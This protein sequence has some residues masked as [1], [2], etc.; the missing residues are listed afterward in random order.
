MVAGSSGY[1]TMVISTASHVPG[2]AIAKR[3]RCRLSQD[4]LLGSSLSRGPFFLGTTHLLKA[5][6]VVSEGRAL[7][8]SPY[9]IATVRCG[10]WGLRYF[11]AVVS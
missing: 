10:K 2:L 4:Q 7:S 6:K 5:T 3:S 9:V 11:D 8:Y 1:G